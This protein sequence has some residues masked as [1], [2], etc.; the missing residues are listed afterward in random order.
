MAWIALQVY[1]LPRPDSLVIYGIR[2]HVMKV[3]TLEELRQFA[4]QVHQN[5]P[6]TGIEH[7]DSSALIGQ[8]AVAYQKLKETYPFLKWG[9]N[10]WDGPS[11]HD[12]GNTVGVEWGGPWLGH[13]GFC[14]SINGQKNDP[15]YNPKP[16]I[17]RMSNDIYF[18]HGE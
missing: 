4:S 7:G 8:Q 16:R 17:L 1:V 3:C 13:R 10:I 5:L 14:V 12:W 9:L 6:N 15:D 11:V 2:D 18:Y